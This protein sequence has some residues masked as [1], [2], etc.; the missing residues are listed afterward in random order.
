MLLLGGHAMQTR[1]AAQVA[2][3]ERVRISDEKLCHGAM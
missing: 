3:H 2:D 1:P